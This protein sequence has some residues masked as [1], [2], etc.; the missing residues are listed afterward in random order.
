MRYRLDRQSRQLAEAYRE[1]QANHSQ[2]AQSE[3]MASLGQLA[4]GVAHEINNPVGYV[5]SNLRTLGEYVSL[6][7][8]SLPAEALDRQVADALDDAEAIITESLDG[9][10]RVADIVDGLKRFARADDDAII[11]SNLNDLIRTTLRV[12]H[13]ELKYQCTIDLRLAELPPINCRPGQINQVLMNL[14]VNARQAISERGTITVSTSVEEREDGRVVQLSVQDD[15]S[16]IKPENLTRLFNPFFTTKPVGEGTGL[17]LSISYA[18]IKEHSGSIS[19]ESE[20]GVG[21][22]FTITLPV[23]KTPATF[24]SNPLL[25]PSPIAA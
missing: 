14:I 2:L 21:T 18:I 5:S 7:R 20:E 11:E 24:D 23:A 6:F 3:K 25:T 19:V 1:L 13:N 10:S 15:G 8:K 12:L 9:T 22:S 4:A 16:G 17:G